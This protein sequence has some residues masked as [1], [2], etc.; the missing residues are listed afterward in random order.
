MNVAILAYSMVALTTLSSGSTTKPLDNKHFL[1]HG[2]VIEIDPIGMEERDAVGTQII[3]YQEGEI[4]VAFNTDEKGK[5]T[6]NLPVGYNY[7]VVY[8]G[9][10]YVN[11]TVKGDGNNIPKKRYGYD[12]ELD[13]GVFSRYE[14]V[15]Y[16]F[17]E[18]PVALIPFDSTN[19]KMIFDEDHSKKQGKAMH[20]CMKKIIKLHG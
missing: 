17:L 18:S 3:V 9:E 16:E 1:I 11:K 20:K 7:E 6:F 14:G 2:E 12:V 15:D 4:Y 8:G 5:Y 10:K 13:M 19:G